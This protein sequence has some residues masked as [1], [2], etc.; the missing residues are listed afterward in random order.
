MDR[1]LAA[2]IV[3]LLPVR[4]ERFLP[5]TCGAR[6]PVNLAARASTLDRS[7]APS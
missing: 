7:P 3:I 5:G 6:A 1:A 4:R 2:R